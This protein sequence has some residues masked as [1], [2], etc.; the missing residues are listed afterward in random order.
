VTCGRRFQAPARQP[1]RWRA[2]HAEA[3]RRARL[4]PEIHPG[5]HVLARTAD[6]RQVHKVAVT[7]IIAGLD[8][9]VVRVRWP[10]GNG[11][12]VPWPAEDVRA[13]DPSRARPLP[14]RRRGRPA[15]KEEAVGDRRR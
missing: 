15:L 11:G 3:A 13:F 12:S 1:Q 4:H 2:I 8:F 7:R 5:A 10:S 14:I 9:P 6:G